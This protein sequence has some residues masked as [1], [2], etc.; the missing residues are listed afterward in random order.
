VTVSLKFSSGTL[1]IRGFPKEQALPEGVQWDDRATL[2]RAPAVLYASLVRTILGLGLELDDQARKYEELTLEARAK[3]EPRP[4]QA[5]G[6]QAWR[7]A[8]GRGVVRRRK[9]SCR[10]DGD[11]GE[12]AKCTNRRADP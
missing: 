9:E 10:G 2:H 8:K 1:E 6:I 5:E 11:S 7:A 12:A 3:R 4:F